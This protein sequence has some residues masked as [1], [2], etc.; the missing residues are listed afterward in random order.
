LKI[1]EGITVQQI[2]KQLALGAF[3]LDEDKKYQGNIVQINQ[4]C[5][6]KTPVTAF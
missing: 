6:L 2:N 4:K 3:E 1:I 5:W